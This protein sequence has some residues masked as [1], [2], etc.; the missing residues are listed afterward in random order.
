MVGEGQMSGHLYR[1]DY[2]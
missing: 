2:W 1:L